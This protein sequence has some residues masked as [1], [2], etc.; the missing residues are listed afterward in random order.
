MANVL[1]EHKTTKDTSAKF[2]VYFETKLEQSTLQFVDHLSA[3]TEVIVLSGIIRNFFIRKTE[4]LRDLDLVVSNCNSSVLA[5]LEKY[6]HRKN[7]FGGYKLRVGNLD[8]DIWELEKTWA[9]S[10][11]KINGFLFHDISLLKTTFFNFSSAI[12]NYNN[13][14]LVLSE[15]FKN[16]LRTREIDFVLE[17]NPAPELCLINTIYYTQRFDLNVSKN[18]K[19]YFVNH[20]FDFAEE[21]FINIQEKHFGRT[22]YQYSYL[23]EYVKIFE[24]SL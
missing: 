15:D 2:G 14:E 9:L 1:T 19:R 10:N 3:L 13:R 24:Q 6:P 7:S 22:K 20:F 23:K 8:V 4:E 18:L 5:L 16:F 21:D 11:N 12:Y 17:D